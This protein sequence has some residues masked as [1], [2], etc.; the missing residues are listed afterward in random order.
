MSDLLKAAIAIA[1]AI[2]VAT[3]LWIYTS[4]YHSCVRI[5]QGKTDNNGSTY[6]AGRIHAICTK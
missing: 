2:V 5:Y 3:G 1:L 6:T 4:P